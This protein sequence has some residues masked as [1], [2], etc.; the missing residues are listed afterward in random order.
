MANPTWTAADGVTITTLI[1]AAPRERIG[2][3]APRVYMESLPGVSGE[4]AQGH[5]YSGR[6]L[7]ATGML[8]SATQATAALASAQLKT[9]IRA[10]QALATGTEVGTFTGEDAHAYTNCVFLG[11]DPGPIMVNRRGSAYFAYANVAA[12][13]RQLVPT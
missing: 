9:Y 6:D 10:R 3:Q 12:R 13:I 11:Y 5:G 2:G 4:F 1:T 7:I 8:Q